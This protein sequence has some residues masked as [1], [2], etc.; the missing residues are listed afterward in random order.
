MN[1][2]FDRLS[3]M[4]IGWLPL[5]FL[6]H[7]QRI[8]H[9]VV[10]VCL[11]MLQL[12][13]SVFQPLQLCC[14]KI[15]VFYTIDNCLHHVL[16]NIIRTVHVIEIIVMLVLYEVVSEAFEH[17]EQDSYGFGILALA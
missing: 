17:F 8:W 1:V 2:F 16:A 11:C 15:P 7:I 13:Q 3:L 14:W 10:F 12:L 6:P 5:E 4:T 9:T